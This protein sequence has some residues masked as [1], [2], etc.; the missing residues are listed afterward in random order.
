M[1]LLIGYG[2]GAVNPWVAF[3]T[4]DDMIRQGLLVGIDHAKAV[5]HYIKAL[6]LAVRNREE[7]DKILAYYQSIGFIVVSHTPG[8]TMT[9]RAAHARGW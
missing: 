6:N 4:L 1:C 9:K 3:E 2:A 7:D 8:A 5:R